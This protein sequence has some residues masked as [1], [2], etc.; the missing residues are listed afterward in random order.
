MYKLYIMTN[1]LKMQWNSDYFVTGSIWLN[2][3]LTLIVRRSFKDKYKITDSH[4]I[5]RSYI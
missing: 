5:C 2:Q 3:L 1:D 4:I